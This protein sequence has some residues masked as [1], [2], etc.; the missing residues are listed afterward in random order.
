MKQQETLL[1][2]DAASPVTG[3]S[4]RG[5]RRSHWRTLLQLHGIIPG[6]LGEDLYISKHFVHFVGCCRKNHHP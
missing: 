1:G 6:R 4:E 3:K 2:D 5:P